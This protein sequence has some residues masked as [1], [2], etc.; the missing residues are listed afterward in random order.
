MLL[1]VLQECT[2]P[3][4]TID[5][6]M[7]WPQNRI[8]DLPGMNFEYFMLNHSQ[9]FITPVMELNE[10]SN[11]WPLRSKEIAKNATLP[12][13]IGFVVMLILLEAKK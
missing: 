9:N 8:P 3:G 11:C 6:D 7:W 4:T 10:L 2:C 5:S 12:Q 13:F 1:L